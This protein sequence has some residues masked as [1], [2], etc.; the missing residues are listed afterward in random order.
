MI[1]LF[2]EAI[3]RA[4]VAVATFFFLEKAI[5]INNIQP[6]AL[7]GYTAVS[8]HI[9]MEL[10]GVNTLYCKQGYACTKGPWTYDNIKNPLG[11][12]K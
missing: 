7:I 1:T 2:I 6:Y 11:G 12:S 4:I 5:N 10:L 3:I 9:I 8:S